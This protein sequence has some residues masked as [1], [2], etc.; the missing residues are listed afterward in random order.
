MDQSI[1]LNP[2][3]NATEY[4][5]AKYKTNYWYTGEPP[6]SYLSDINKSTV[7]AERSLG[8]LINSVEAGFSKRRPG[9][10]EWH[11]YTPEQI[12]RALFLND[13]IN[14]NMLGVL[15][16]IRATGKFATTDYVNSLLSLIKDAGRL[17]IERSNKEE[18]ATKARNASENRRRITSKLIGWSAVLGTL[19]TECAV[20]SKD[21]YALITGA[22]LTGSAIIGAIIRG[23]S[24]RFSNQGLELSSLVKDILGIGG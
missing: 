24:A 22:S 18:A 11:T 8:A 16:T 12:V 14:Q 19:V 7:L 3:F 5:D 2:L 4:K 9:I 15:G 21:E 20:L 6:A 13:S 17:Y 23:M 10:K 1:E